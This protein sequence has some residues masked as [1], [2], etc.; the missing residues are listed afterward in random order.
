MTMG[1]FDKCLKALDKQIRKQSQIIAFLI[2]ICPVHLQN[3]RE[4]LQNVEVIFLSSN[5]IFKTTAYG[6]GMI[7]ILKGAL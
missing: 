5:Y 1:I 4:E 7:K 3:C 2:D 6:S